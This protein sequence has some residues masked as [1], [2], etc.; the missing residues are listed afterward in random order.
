MEFSTLLQGYLGSIAKDRNFSYSSTANR[1]DVKD[2]RIE[3]TQDVEDLFGGGIVSQ[4]LNAQT[5]AKKISRFIK[6][7]FDYSS[8]ITPFGL[9][10]A[11]ITIGEK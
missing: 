4:S 11:R 5:F 9:G 1:I 8:N 2:L 6:E 7:N 3:L 10:K